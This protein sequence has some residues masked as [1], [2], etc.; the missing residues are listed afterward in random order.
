M[1][2]TDQPRGKPNLLL[3]QARL[4]LGLTQEELAE[5]IETTKVSISRWEND[6]SKKPEPRYY[7]K[8]LIA[9]KKQ[10]LQ[11]L[12]FGLEEEEQKLQQA[13]DTTT[14]EGHPRQPSV[15]SMPYTRR[16]PFFTGREDILAR[17]FRLLATTE[18]GQPIR[19]VAI[20]G[21][22][23]VG[24]TQ[25]ILEYAWR[26][27]ADYRIICWA[28]A[29]DADTLRAEFARIAREL[30]L[31]E[32]ASPDQQ[33][34][35]AALKTWM[36]E[37][38]QW[39]IVLDDVETP[40]VLQGFLPEEPLG[41][42]VL[43]GRAQAIGTIAQTIDLLGMEPEEGAWFLLRRTQKLALD[44]PFDS[45]SL[46]D[47]QQARAISQALG[48]LPLALEQAGAYIEETGCRLLSYRERYREQHAELL[49]RRGALSDPAY[50]WS[51][52]TTWTL[53]LTR[54]KQRNLAAAEL[55]YFLACLNP[56]AVPLSL[57]RDAAPRL[58][59]R[60]RRTAANAV[61]LDEAIGD[62]RRFSLVQRH[63]GDKIPRGNEVLAMHPVVQTVLMDALPEQMQRRWAERT[64]KAVHRAFAAGIYIRQ[65]QACAAL[66]KQW[67]LF[68]KEAA[69]LL[70]QAGCQ[71]QDRQLN[72]IAGLLFQ[73]ALPICER[74][75]TTNSMSVVC[76]L[77]RIAQV[78]Q[79]R[80]QFEE[81]E[82][83]YR[84][85]L[86]IRTHLR[87]SAP[88]TV[89][90][91]KL[92]LGRLY[93][94]Q[95]KDAQAEA[96]Y[97]E[98]A[99]H[100]SQDIALLESRAVLSI[101]QERYAEAEE[102]IQQELALLRS[103]LEPAQPGYFTVTDDRTQEHMDEFVVFETTQPGYLKVTAVISYL[104][105]LYF[106]Q[107][108]LAE[109]E[110]LIQQELATLQA[111]LEPTDDQVMT[112]SELLV[113]IY[114]RQ[115]RRADAEA[116]LRHLI[117]LHEQ[118]PGKD[119]KEGLP[120]AGNLLSLAEVL[121]D[122]GAHEEADGCYRRALAIVDTRERRE[123]ALLLRLLMSYASFLLI[124]ERAEEAEQLMARAGALSEEIQGQ[125]AFWADLS[126]YLNEGEMLRDDAAGSP[127]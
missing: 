86:G 74:L 92:A 5:T 118:S 79:A 94:Q 89:A 17:L 12:G 80:Q 108:K 109:A 83:Y 69:D 14:D 116:L 112:M 66:I 59:R 100:N 122:K 64:I 16:N 76:C 73:Q 9:L 50:P 52:A 28:K 115:D 126:H 41:H 22:G 72:H 24:K 34:A 48:G 96:I 120:I 125:N 7:R 42:L 101:A 1:A 49:K 98:L 19:P 27:R 104:T 45:A 8:L 4:E 25:T 21:L 26:H 113:D 37:Q 102:F 46:L 56:D 47:Q 114:R 82:S 111:V 18:E 33:E 29:G 53:S 23:G 70:Y 51:V 40:E 103:S 68:S 31:P 85:A 87:S 54:V 77:I 30:K 20:T 90:W 60:L 81:A 62:L 6:S 58:P 44:A 3:K 36:N 95:R 65:A 2:K 32:A 78:S 119:M 39:L 71:A 105:A 124:T 127:S 43:T 97:Q 123:Q 75:G 117:D 93:T 67:G 107:G 38:P 11:E 121:V 110:T 10:S 13:D 88:P 57:I 106:K 35:I 15:W 63:E 61:K 84:R 55:L 91:C 99:E